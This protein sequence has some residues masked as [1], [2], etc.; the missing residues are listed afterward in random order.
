MNWIHRV[1][2]IYWWTEDG[3]TVWFDES[4]QYLGFSEFF[5]TTEHGNRQNRRRRDECSQH[6]REKY[7][8]EY[9][10]GFGTSLWKI[11]VVVVSLITPPSCLSQSKSA[12]QIVKWDGGPH[13]IRLLSS[14]TL[15]SLRATHSVRSPRPAFHLQLRQSRSEAR[16]SQFL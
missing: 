12:I 2:S 9:Q 11:S 3:Q 8:I 4:V 15:W 5:A 13:L 6:A 14:Q 16:P 7:L 10:C 1:D